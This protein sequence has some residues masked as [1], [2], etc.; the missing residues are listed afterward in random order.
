[1]ADSISKVEMV[2]NE[3]QMFGRDLISPKW[4]DKNFDELP[5]NVREQFT[6]LVSEDIPRGAFYAEPVVPQ[7]RPCR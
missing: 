3:V 6:A 5:K 4:L 1:M 7:P 2:W